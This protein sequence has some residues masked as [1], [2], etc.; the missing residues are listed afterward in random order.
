MNSQSSP[1]TDA[2]KP[3]TELGAAELARGVRAGQFSAVEVFEAHRARIEAVNPQLNAVVVP[4]FDRAR[5]QAESIDAARRRGEPLGPLAGVPLTVKECLDVA[6]TA[7]SLGVPQLARRIAADDG[8][9]V[10]RLCAA[11]AVVMGKTNLPQLAMYLETDGPMFGR[12]N[13]PWNPDRSPGGSSGGEAA[14]LA[15]GGSALGLAT[16]AGGSI[17]QPA[18][19]CGVHGFKP[20]SGRLTQADLPVTTTRSGEVL[21]PVNLA[22]LHAILQ[23]GPMARRVED[24]KLAMDVLATPDSNSPD[25]TVP[26]IQW[27]DA[28]RVEVGRLKIGIYTDDGDF[29]VAPAIRRAIHEAAD[30]LRATGAKVVPFTPPKVQ[31][32][33]RIFRG[34]LFPD[35]GRA[36][37][38][39]LG[40]TQLDPRLKQLM[41]GATLHNL[42]RPPMAWLLRLAGQDRAA[43]GV[44]SMG[45]L[46][47][48]A[49]R[50]KI[51]ERATYCA[52]FVDAL[53][54][55][56][57]D[58]IL[59]PPH[60]VPAPTHGSGAYLGLLAAY[61]ALYNLLGMP[62]GVVAATRVRPGEETDRAVGRDKAEQVAHEVEQG[63]RG[64]PIGVQV[65]ARY[66]RE[67][68]ALRVMQT[69]E[70]HFRRQ[71]DYPLTPPEHATDKPGKAKR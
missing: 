65:A 56:R 21:M 58:A 66:W 38:R 40:S 19:C 70:D 63:S 54:R 47:A 68:I 41:Q 60:A 51:A 32:A 16:D 39:M 15:A 57:I 22:G 11:G 61:S 23:C 29:P 6:G 53:N 18:H 13:N 10:A 2:A 26:P 45:K 31:H 3:L 50:R 14:I 37:Q 7:S 20:T 59:C 1:P 35:G 52:E 44:L 48:D 64:L 5:Q 28:D 4:L 67:D 71:A 25:P 69:L 9:L 24:L 17:R 55:D 46:S 36:F 43:D 42:L 27:P 30:A 49:Y 34:L 12:T 33:M 62:A 8:P